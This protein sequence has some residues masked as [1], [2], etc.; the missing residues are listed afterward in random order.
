MKVRE[1]KY[2]KI[3]GKPYYYCDKCKKWKPQHYVTDNEWKKLPQKYQ[4]TSLCK[5]C[6]LEITKIT[7]KRDML[8]GTGTNFD[9]KI[10]KILGQEGKMVD[11][12]KALEKMLGKPYEK[13]DYFKPVSRLGGYTNHD[14]PSMEEA[15]KKQKSMK[16]KFGYT[17]EIFKVSGRELKKPLYRVVEPHNLEKL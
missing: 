11:T 8:L 3:N 6:F 13:S 1:T 17:P 4:N 16:R 2:K 12:E 10:K 14:F 15:V 7:P 9:N 5:D